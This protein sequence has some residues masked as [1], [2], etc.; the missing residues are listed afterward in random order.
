MKKYLFKLNKKVGQAIS[1]LTKIEKKSL[2]ELV[3]EYP[4]CNYLFVHFGHGTEEDYSTVQSFIFSVGFSEKEFLLDIFAG[5]PYGLLSFNE[6]KDSQLFSQRL[7][8][9]KDSKLKAQYGKIDSSETFYQTQEERKEKKNFD[10]SVNQEI[11]PK[12][13]LKKFIDCS[14]S[15]KFGFIER[16]CLFLPT[17]LQNEDLLC[18]HSCTNS[19]P[20]ATRYVKNLESFGLF[21][22][23]NVVS[24]SDQDQII[25]L[26]NL[27]GWENLSH[28]R[29]QHFGYQF[30]YGANSIN[31]E[32]K[33]TDIPTSIQDVL[34]HSDLKSWV[35]DK[36]SFDQITAND[37]R[38]GG[39]IPPHTDSHA[40]FEETIISISLISDIVMT[41]RDPLSGESYHI[42]LPARSALI[43]TGVARYLWTHQIA[44]RKVDRV[45]K[46]LLFRRH[47]ISLT[48]RKI[49][50]RPFCACNYAFKCDF[51]SEKKEEQ[52]IIPQEMEEREF[53]KSHVQEVYNRIG[54][55]FSHTR[56]KPWPRVSDFLAE[57]PP[58]SLV[59]DIGC[60]NGKYL[61][62]HPSLCMIG[63]DSAVT[64][65]EIIREKSPEAQFIAADNLYLPFKTG[66]FDFAISIAVVHHLSTVERRAQAVAELLRIVKPS[67][68][69]LIFVWAFEQD[70][71]FPAQ[72]VFVDWNNQIKYEGSELSSNTPSTENKEKGT[73]VYKRFYHLFKKG[74]LEELVAFASEK[75]SLHLKIRESFYNHQNWCVIVEKL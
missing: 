12:T 72:D 74:E 48:Y 39:G 15:L 5:Y 53:E 29:V 14:I 25:D 4:S 18:A 38:P 32:D 41:F 71:D 33:K 46:E 50:S 44:E 23:E 37:Y 27:H 24:P 11:F 9:A 35:A 20:V 60:G 63:S 6:L 30:I 17:K 26:L 65:G 43:M 47:R 7:K 62:D 31:R 22:V 19:L 49:K 55:H 51:R 56:Y 2:E 54:R 64:F 67:G 73:V 61:W 68:A 1:L 45:E 8:D 75:Y 36:F 34:S 59:A 13:S 70:K 28:R 10:E 57:L 40:P 21:L 58:A 42:F 3:T 52:A 16:N 66:I 69:V